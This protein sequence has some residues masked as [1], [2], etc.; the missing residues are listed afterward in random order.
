MNSKQLSALEKKI[1]IVFFFN[2]LFLVL[3]ALLLII[4]TYHYY[5]VG[6]SFDLY[7][8][9]ITILNII[10]I[11]LSHLA[12]D[13]LNYFKNKHRHFSEKNKLNQE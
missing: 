13:K 5:V 4:P 1:K 11:Y 10:G 6:F 8:L 9:I 3:N 7:F 12:T 2:L